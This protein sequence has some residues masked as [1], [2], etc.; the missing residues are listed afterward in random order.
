[1]ISTWGLEPTASPDDFEAGWEEFAIGTR[2][3]VLTVSDGQYVEN[4][5][6]RVG[7]VRATPEENDR[8]IEVE[9]DEKWHNN[10]DFY[11]GHGA[12]VGVYMRTRREITASIRLL[13]ND[14]T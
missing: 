2:V 4:G 6:W 8:A 9:C 7:T 14:T 1:M 12:T 3:E 11:K 10:L 13:H 5:V